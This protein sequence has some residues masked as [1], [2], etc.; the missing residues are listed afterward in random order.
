MIING[1]P[2]VVPSEPHPVFAVGAW[3]SDSINSKRKKK[4][5]KQGKQ[6]Y[7]KLCNNEQQVILCQR[8]G[9][10]SM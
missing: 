9:K 8:T 6:N 3:L 5:Q 2:G 7:S 4:K 1:L 10:F